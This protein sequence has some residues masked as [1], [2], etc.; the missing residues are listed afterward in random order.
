MTEADFVTIE[1]ALGIVVPSSYRRV[2]AAYPFSNDRPSDA[3]IPD[4]AQYVCDLNRQVLADNVYPDSWRTGFFAIGTSWGGDAYVLDTS[5]DDP[6]VYKLDQD[7]DV[8]ST[9]APTLDE[10][11]GKLSQWYVHFDGVHAATEY[12]QLT[13]AIRNAGFY[14]TSPE[15]MNGWHRV[16]VSSCRGGGN[17]FWVAVVKDRWFIGAWS[18]NIYRI[19]DNLS[20]FCVA[21]LTES[22]DSTDFRESIQNEYKLESVTEAQFDNVVSGKIEL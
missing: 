7:G 22:Q 20:G 2:M 17:S 11:V 12:E 15:P 6:P 5:L 19:P 8:L 16:I 10:W 3:Y 9:L 4:N 1:Q 18:G 14:T 13:S 21:W